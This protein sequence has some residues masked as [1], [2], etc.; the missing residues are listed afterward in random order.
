MPPI[1]SPPPTSPPPTRPPSTSPPTIPP[2]T[3][4]P[5]SSGNND[6]I[7]SLIDQLAQFGDTFQDVINEL[8]SL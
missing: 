2:P 5:F 6:Q 7:Q 1:S 4:P 8:R 3:L